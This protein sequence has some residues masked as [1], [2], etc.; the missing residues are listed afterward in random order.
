MENTQLSEISKRIE[1]D[2]EIA[3]REIYD[4][5]Y[6]DLVAFSRQIVLD[7]PAAEDAVENV[8]IRLWQNRKTL[9]NINNLSA[10]LY[11]ATKYASINYLKA[12]KNVSDVSIED[13]DDQSLYSF[14]T[15]ETSMIGKE[16]VLTIEKAIN[17]LPPK[18]KLV[19]YLVK[20]KGLNC[21]EVAKIL[22]SSVRTVETQLY[23][24]LK[25]I[26]AILEESQVILPRRSSR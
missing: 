19:F 1:N 4:L 25:K 18:S 7:D 6:F 21:R 16:E 15:P 13:L 9:G 26:A 8:F 5:F 20:E 11:T 14:S 10:Y 23:H 22:N 2:D 17:Q 24:S 3:F 12:R